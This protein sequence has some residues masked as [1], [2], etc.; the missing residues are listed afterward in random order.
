MNNNYNLSI[1]FSCAFQGTISISI[2]N[3]AGHSFIYQER[4]L[5]VADTSWSEPKLSVTILSQPMGNSIRTLD[6]IDEL[7]KVTRRVAEQVFYIWERA[8]S[9]YYKDELVSA[10]T[11]IRSEFIEPV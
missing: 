5:L 1:E 9:K 8:D 10:Y 6:A 11:D 4:G 3:D 7:V 2:L